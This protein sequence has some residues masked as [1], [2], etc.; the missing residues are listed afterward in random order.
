M[1]ASS[2][3]LKGRLWGA[4]AAALLA[5]SFGLAAA[6]GPA[7]AD[8]VGV[9]AAVNP[10]AFSSLAGS[11]QSQLSIGKSI[12]F[13]ERINTT[14]SGLVQVLLID[15]ST[16]T[17]GPGSD[18]VI[19]KFVYDPKKG[20]GQITA[21]F[22]KGVMRFVGGKISKN[23]NGVTVNTPAGALAI[24][25]C[26]V[27][28]KMLP[29]GKGI[30]SFLYGVSMTLAN[31]Y[32]VYEKGYTI[33]TTSGTPDVR[34][35]RQADINSIMAALTNGN[36]GGT[37][38]PGDS[39]GG[40]KPGNKY[41][42]VETLS[43]QDMISE[44]TA[45]QINDTLIK[46]ETTETP[47]DNTGNEPDPDPDPDPDPEPTKVTVRV[48]SAPNT[49]TAYDTNFED[50]ASNG[51]LGGDDN[52]DVEVDDFVWTFNIEN[53]RLVGTVEGLTDTFEGEIGPMTPADVNF[54]ATFDQC[55]DGICAVTDATITQDGETDTFVGLAVLKKDFFA[56]HL[57]EF[58]EPDIGQST[59][60]LDTN[61]V[62]SD[63]LLIFG[64]TAH[65]F[66][67]PSGKTYAFLLLPDVRE[68]MN[69][70]IAPFAGAGSFPNIDTATDEDGNFIKP[71][72][73]ISPLLYLEKDGGENDPSRAVWL[74]TSLY[75]N[76]TPDDPLTEGND[77]D[78]QSF[79][80]IALG[81]I[82]EDGGLVGARRGGASV[83]FVHDNCDGPCQ[84][85]REAFAFTGD[86]ASLAGPDGSHFLGKD[87][88]NVV[89]GFDS[90]AHNIGRDIPLDPNSSDIQNQSGATYHI[91]V[92]LG[93]LEPQ[94]Q[95]LNG[96][97]KGYAVGMVQSEIPASDF[98]NV[99]ASNSPDDFTITF[100]KTANSILA[101][102]TVYSDIQRSGDGAT[103]AYEFSFGDTNGSTGRSAY[104]NNTSYAAIESETTAENKAA[105]VFNNSGQA[106]DNASAT[107]Y[108]ASGDQLGVTNFFPET[109]TTVNLD[110]TRPFCD[111]CEF[112]QWGVWG[113]RVEFGPNGN[114]TQLVDNVHL[115]LWIGGDIS[116]G[117]QLDALQVDALE[118][119]DAEAT[120]AGHAIGNVASNLGPDGWKTYVAAGNLD[121]TWHFGS[122]T[123]GLT[124]SNFDRSVT[125]E[126]L[127]F[128]GPMSA[129]GVI[130]GNHFSGPLSGQLPSDLGSLS[131]SAAGSFANNG[132]TVAAGVIG[133]WNIGN[134]AY[135]AAGIFAGAKQ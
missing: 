38:T 58:Q 2:P 45:T 75:I 30:F 107:S 25:G 125:P 16:F 61:P 70:V 83:D 48:L 67:A 109:F 114:P 47:T 87:D 122:R 91:G 130:D 102:L 92:G 112:L 65:D 36:S 86:I 135:N 7:E 46:E 79:V 26:I 24:R 132:N 124:I 106:Y 115:G 18:L 77:F 37:G 10:D 118:A 111:N 19:D 29:N 97:L 96:E 34:P 82:G 103:S 74:Q 73:V 110:G 63:P 76:T 108:I 128:S 72:P 60:A 51:I 4:S 55:V 31:K 14:G 35:T 113:T 129:P 131:G 68:G 52:P 100:N 41:T 98:I 78:Q 59:H 3:R 27:Q 119:Q 54:P 84:T 17:V 133:N 1:G 13:N 62:Y 28:S 8:K 64:G 95:T 39:T 22:S 69:G 44:A 21:S 89:I 56:Y 5:L 121:M 90:T 49:Y 33:D 42:E 71:L 93:A 9:A 81:G 11:P 116:T 57:V 15:G 23:E 12:F 6:I 127:T 126:G 101:N 80:N 20:T 32:T 123:G 66:G 120:F 134:N 40:P 105:Q 104:I 99:V 94:A 85:Q 43:L 53:G 117:A 50:P 88:P